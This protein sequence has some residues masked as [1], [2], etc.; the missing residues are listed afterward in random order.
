MAGQNDQDSEAIQA[1][2]QFLDQ[3]ASDE[4]GQNDQDSEDEATQ[5]DMD[6]IDDDEAL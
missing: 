2:R 6:F 5:S 4:N 3:E 1:A